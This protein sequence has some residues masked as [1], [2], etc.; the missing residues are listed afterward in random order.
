MQWQWICLLLQW[1]YRAK[2]WNSFNTSLVRGTS[3]SPDSLTQRSCKNSIL[4]ILCH[5][6]EIC[7]PTYN[8]LLPFYALF[9]PC[10]PFPFVLPINQSIKDMVLVF[11]KNKKI[12]DMV[13]FPAHYKSIK[14][15][16]Q[17]SSLDKTIAWHTLNAPHHRKHKFH[18][19]S[20]SQS[21]FFIVKRKCYLNHC[22]NILCCLHKFM[23]IQSTLHKQQKSTP[24]KMGKEDQTL[25]KSKISFE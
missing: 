20:R 5:P 23:Q 7:I 6:K 3:T 17:N 1:T 19:V 10:Y 12:K 8:K 18:L 15:T 21:L 16:A 24:L 9:L 22:P 2:P 4:I 25:R 14:Q 13:Q 11:K